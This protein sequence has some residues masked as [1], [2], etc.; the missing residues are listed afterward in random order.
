M[1]YLRRVLVISTLLAPLEASAADSVSVKDFGAVGDGIRDDTEAIQNAIKDANGS[2]FFPKGTYRISDTLVI[3][4]PVAISST[5]D[6]GT[7]ILGSQCGTWG[8]HPNDHSP[9]I[10]IRPAAGPKAKSFAGV[11]VQNLTLDGG[12][13]IRTYRWEFSAGIEVQ[14]RGLFAP[15]NVHLLR[16]H[17]RDV[18]GDGITVR[19]TPEGKTSRALPSEIFIEENT[20]ERW[21]ANRQGIA[22]VAGRH[23]IIAN[24]QIVLGIP[25]SGVCPP[26]KSP[27]PTDANFGIDLES[28]P[29]TYGEFVSQIQISGNLIHNCNGGINIANQHYPNN[30]ISNISVHGNTIQAYG[31]LPLKPIRIGTVDEGVTRVVK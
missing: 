1:N 9:L 16:L 8:E 20:I 15:R 27:D 31:R 3:E 17:I 26:P 4:K 11:T 29:G 24:N 18:S 22:V 12:C 13:T 30:A 21:H 5:I 7:V 2:V 6:G 23:V 10:R 25:A 28:N 19:G 14:A